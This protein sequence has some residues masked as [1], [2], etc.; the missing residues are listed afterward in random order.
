MRRLTAA[1]WLKALTGLAAAV[2]LLLG[3]KLPD[4]PYLS[5]R[6]GRRL[7]LA[8][9]LVMATGGMAF[10]L[11]GG[12]G[13]GERRNRGDSYHYYI[14]AK[15]FPEVGY[16]GL[17]DC[18]LAAELAAGQVKNIGLRAVRDLRSMKLV[19]AVELAEHIYGCRARFSP[20]R[21]RDFRADIGW[22]RRH[23]PPELW[24]DNLKDHGFNASPAWLLLGRLFVAAGPVSQLR[25]RLLAG[26]DYLVLGLMWLLVFY[27]FGARRG[28]AAAA[29]WLSNL[30]ARFSYSH[31]AIIRRPWLG[32]TVGAVC[33]LRKER[34]LL[35]GLALGAAAQLRIFPLALL[36][37]PALNLLPRLLGGTRPRFP[38]AHRG[39]A[40][41]VLLSLAVLVPAAT[42]AGG[43][44]VWPRFVS[45]MKD[46]MATPLA[47]NMGLSVVASYDHRLRAARLHV[48]GKADR[49]SAWRDARARTYQ[50]RRPV[51]VFLIGAFL[52][53][54]LFAVRGRPVW[55]SALLGV[56]LLPVAM[57]VPSYYYSLLLGYGLLAS[58]WPGVAAALNL[59]ASAGWGVAMFWPALDEQYTWLSALSVLF[60][61][62][63]TARAAVASREGP[64]EKVPDA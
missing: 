38:L 41:G 47:N 33:A 1:E 14:G 25:L 27:T 60:V 8:L 52:M 22:F 20:E 24:R 64:G 35:A 44:D 10:W 50:T 62:G 37:G 9:M 43:V 58:P 6:A 16:R 45:K 29:Y 32:L 11:L 49:Y 5:S 13:E 18:T 39:L 4:V 56:G 28:L 2:W 17:Y 55:V 54:L 57:E 63:A 48:G 12:P 19:R 40:L 30:P 61:V 15:Y 31:G 26:V 34:P 23:T 53:L 36:V 21:W 42:L 59:Y 46:H 3:A 51:H 7:I